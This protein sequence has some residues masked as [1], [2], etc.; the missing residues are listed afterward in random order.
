MLLDELAMAVQWSQHI[1]SKPKMGDEIVEYSYYADTHSL[2]CDLDNIRLDEQCVTRL[3]RAAK[4]F[5]EAPWPAGRKDLVWL[6][7]ADLCRQRLS[8]L[9]KVIREEFLRLNNQEEKNL[10][11]CTEFAAQIM[12]DSTAEYCAELQ[13]ERM[14]CEEETAKH[15]SLAA[16]KADSLLEEI[17]QEQWPQSAAINPVRRKQTKAKAE[18]VAAAAAP[19]PSTDC[20]ATAVLHEPTCASSSDLPVPTVSVKKESLSFFRKMFPPNGAPLQSDTRWQNF[21]QAMADAG[22]VVQEAAG[23]AVSFS[24][25]AG[26]I[27]F[28]RPHPDPVIDPIMMHS[29]AKRIRKW[30]GFSSETFVLRS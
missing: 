9:W 11:W 4:L 24:N 27:C 28:H 19:R 22:F 1:W 10:A 5:C 15:E 25:E 16:A 29:M 8:L 21:L 30:F 3:G 13:Q 23:S 20:K 14:V 6:S 26:S 18:R 17:C 2:V 7:K 12:F